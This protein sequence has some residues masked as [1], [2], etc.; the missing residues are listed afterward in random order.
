[1]QYLCINQFR[2]ASHWTAYQGGTFA[3]ILCC[4]SCTYLEQTIPFETTITSQAQRFLDRCF[5]YWTSQVLCPTV[6]PCIL[7]GLHTPWQYVQERIV[8]FTCRISECWY[9]GNGLPWRLAI[10][11]IM[12]LIIEIISYWLPLF[13]FLFFAST[14]SSW[15]LLW[16]C[17][18]KLL[19]YGALFQSVS[20][21]CVI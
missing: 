2:H 11:T 20:P 5:T 8:G 4:S 1:M 12:E 7:T 13:S 15:S 3:F 14:V 10:W 6:L 21:F 17:L 9:K 16:I 19:Q 18:H